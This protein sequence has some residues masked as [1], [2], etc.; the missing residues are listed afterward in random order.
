MDR[1]LYKA[2]HD[3]VTTADKAALLIEKEVIF[4]TE[5]NT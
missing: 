4:I 3:K 5:P 1:I 2:Y